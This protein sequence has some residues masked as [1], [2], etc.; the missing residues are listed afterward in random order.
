MK[1]K[2]TSKGRAKV[3]L[4]FEV[5]IIDSRLTRDFHKILARIYEK[6][7]VHLTNPEKAMLLRKIAATFTTGTR[8]IHAQ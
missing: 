8:R 3:N 4:A 5:Y 6:A 7:E 1:P 2:V